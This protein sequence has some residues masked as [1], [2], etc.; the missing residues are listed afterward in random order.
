LVRRWLAATIRPLK[1]HVWPIDPSAAS[2]PPGWIGWPEGKNFA[3]VLSHD[4]ETQRGHDNCLK[5]MEIEKQLGFRSS[6]SLVP[7]RYQVAPDLLEIMREQG[8]QICVHGLKHDGKL[9]RSRQLFE[10]RAQIINQYLENWKAKGF[11]S[12]SMH[13]ELDW[14]HALNIQHSTS[15]FD[16]DPFEPQPDGVKTIFPFMVQNGIPG[17]GYIELPYTLPQDFT[18]FILLK[19]ERI[20]IWMEKL[21]WIAKSG[22]MALLVTHPDYMNFDDRACGP[23]EYPSAL[24]KQFLDHVRTHYADRYYHALPRE[25]ANYW[26]S[27][28][29]PALA[30]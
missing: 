30:N 19:E 12:P 21:A 5:L 11:S 2:I 29:S 15:T 24:Y 8:F 1:K 4:V 17:K 14:L 25:I 3:L 18:L 7:E 20:D 10:E 22:G 26:T 6:F 16:T 28:T 13:H 9:F 23:E 27:I